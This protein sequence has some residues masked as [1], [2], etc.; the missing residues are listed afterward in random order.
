MAP[1]RQ[2]R[3][4]ARPAAPAR[5]AP[6]RDFTGGSPRFAVEWDVRPSYDFLFSLSPEC[7]ATDD[8]PA[9][10]RR[11]LK[12]ARAA[13][14]ARTQDG[15]GRLTKEEVPIH[16]AGYIVDHPALSTAGDVV[17][18]MR[19]DGPAT[20]LRHLFGDMSSDGTIDPMVEQA[21]EGDAEAIAELRSRYPGAKHAVGTAALDDPAAEFEAVMSILEGWAEAFA[22]V[23][24]RVAAILQRDFDL[25]AEDRAALS[26]TE[27]VERT[28]NGIRLVP[29]PGIRR[30]I[31]AP[32][33]FSRPYNFLL[34]GS[35]WRFYGYPVADAALDLDPLAP[36]SGVLRLHR[37]LGDE[38]RLR[39]LKLLADR[40]LY[41][42][43][44]AELLELSKP[45]I[46]H[47]LAMLRAAG[48][49]T[50]IEAGPVIYYHLR[51]ER[52]EEATG[53][54]RAFLGS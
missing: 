22:E 13:L 44:I 36:P 19:A 27:L 41:L 33:Y 21:L 46:K 16:L 30:V 47:H 40:D 26:G 52:L 53:G 1:N 3:T 10:D 5:V 8:L 48:L 15:F 6:V 38:T 32:S 39:I 31:L 37:A 9:P 43:E 25:R 34:G 2:A 20:V 42:T 17:R 45:T 24:P 14:A 50:V 11:W 49:L 51:R 54:L 12:D 28:T 4:I 7:G 35:D 18:S 23:E 29:E